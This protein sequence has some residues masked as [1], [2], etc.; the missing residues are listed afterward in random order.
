[1]PKKSFPP[2]T[3]FQTFG[4]N[5]KSRD[6]R[7]RDAHM[8]QIGRNRNTFQSGPMPLHRRSDTSA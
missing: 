6:V 4:R 7:I 8:S 2:K 5:L 3:M 1:M